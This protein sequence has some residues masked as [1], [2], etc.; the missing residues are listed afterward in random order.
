MK[1]PSFEIKND[2]NS[3]TAAITE[4]GK[5]LCVAIEFGCVGMY[6]YI[7]SGVHS[8]NYIAI[9]ASQAQIHH[10]TG[11]CNIYSGFAMSTKWRP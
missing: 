4:S 5:Y 7:N 8:F 3:Q 11:W 10:I 2:Y 6:F 9:S 1:F